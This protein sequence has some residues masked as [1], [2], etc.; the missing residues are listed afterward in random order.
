MKCF[1]FLFLTLLDGISSNNTYCTV[2]D[3]LRSNSFV[4]VSDFHSNQE[5][6]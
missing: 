6:L 4:E 5:P 2:T 1:Q 3:M